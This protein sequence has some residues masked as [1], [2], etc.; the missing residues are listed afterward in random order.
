MD[1]FL[2]Q[3]IDGD[4]LKSFIIAY[5]K[6]SYLCVAFGLFTC[7]DIDYKSIEPYI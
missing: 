5:L 3:D 1:G 2:S 6:N 4:S 7:Q